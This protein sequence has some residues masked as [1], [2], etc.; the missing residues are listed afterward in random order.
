MTSRENRRVRITR[1]LISDLERCVIRTLPSELHQPHCG[2]QRA[3][4]VPCQGLLPL[5]H[6]DMCGSATPV[7][8]PLKGTRAEDS[9]VTDWSGVP[10]N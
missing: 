7:K 6:N 3:D 5:G 1:R 9:M 8:I 2:Y 10:K 4:G